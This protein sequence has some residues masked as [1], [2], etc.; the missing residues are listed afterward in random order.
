MVILVVAAPVLLM[1]MYLFEYIRPG[2]AVGSAAD[3][4]PLFGFFMRQGVSVNVIKYGKYFEEQ[5]NPDAHYALYSTL[6]WINGNTLFELLGVEL[7]FAFGKQSVETA[8]N[9]TYL[10]DFV[11]FHA[12]RDS[13]L[14]GQGY[15][16]SY[17]AELYAD[18]GYT[19][20]LLGSVL[21]GAVIAGVYRFAPRKGYCWVYAMG[22]FAAD[23]LLTAPRA[24]FDA[25]FVKPLYVDFWMPVVIV[26]AVY[27][28]ETIMC[29][30]NRLKKMGKTD[31]GS[32]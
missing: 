25:C 16:S 4:F 14:A 23:S 28:R 32:G 15:G 13:Y 17:V 20:V 22:L 2:A 30:L 12:N 18:M 10:A 9:G 24:S 19:G 1:G 8:I 6:K 11:S 21:Y 29:W 27:H 31:K 7:P 3:N 5:M 26:L